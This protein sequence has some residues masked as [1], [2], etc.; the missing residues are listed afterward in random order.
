ML[1]RD[2]RD[3]TIKPSFEVKSDRRNYSR[4]DSSNRG[5]DSLRN[6]AATLKSMWKGDR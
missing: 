5:I 1:H 4:S 2:K 6:V 3:K